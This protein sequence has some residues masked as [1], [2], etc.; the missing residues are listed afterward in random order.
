M[1]FIFPLVIFSFAFHATTYAAAPHYNCFLNSQLIT[2]PELSQ[3][4]IDLLLSPK[5]AI[6]IRENLRHAGSLAPDPC[7]Q[8]NQIYNLHID[9]HN[10][11]HGA[12]HYR[13]TEDDGLQKNQGILCIRD[14]NVADRLQREHYCES[15][16]R[17]EGAEG[18]EPRG[19]GPRTRDE[20]E[21]SW[22]G[23]CSW[24][25]EGGSGWAVQ[26]AHRAHPESE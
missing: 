26:P 23:F 10:G 11:I 6:N 5:N 17:L 2:H 25:G 14:S 13:A 20:C 12:Y 4:D 9:T 8:I 22:P 19:G 24:Q 7:E 1:R 3:A 16:R 15:T 21:G 18:M